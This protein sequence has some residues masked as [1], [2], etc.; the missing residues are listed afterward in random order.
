MEDAIE[1]SSHG[2]LCSPQQQGAAT[3]VYCAAAPELEGLG[4]MYFNNCFRCQPSNQAQDQSS[5]PVGAQRAP[6][7]GEVSG[8]TSPLDWQTRRRKRR[9][10]ASQNRNQRGRS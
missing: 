6:G 10:G 2:C 5:Q 1:L 3:T 8:D 9:A 4:G 7:G